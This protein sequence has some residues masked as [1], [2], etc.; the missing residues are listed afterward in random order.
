MCTINPTIIG[1]INL[2]CNFHGTKTWDLHFHK[3]PIRIKVS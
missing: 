1:V 2:G 3:L